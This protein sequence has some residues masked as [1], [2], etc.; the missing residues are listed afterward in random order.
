MKLLL[1]IAFYHSNRKITKTEVVPRKKE[2]VA[3]R[4]HDHAG[5]FLFVC[6]FEELRRL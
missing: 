5:F 1:V 6:L 2:I 3:L 4:K